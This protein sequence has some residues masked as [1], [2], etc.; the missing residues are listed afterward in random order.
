MIPPPP[1]VDQKLARFVWGLRLPFRLLRTALSETKLRASFT[2]TGTLSSGVTLVTALFLLLYPGTRGFFIKEKD[3][4]VDAAL[5]EA[6]PLPPG[7][8]EA[9]RELELEARQLRSELRQLLKSRDNEEK[10]EAVEA[11]TS[12]SELVRNLRREAVA[13]SKRPRTAP[14]DEDEDPLQPEELAEARKERREELDAALEKLRGALALPPVPPSEVE[15]APPLPLPPVARIGKPVP[16]SEVEGPPAPLPAPVPPG[17]VED[18]GPGLA[19]AVKAIS[20]VAGAM[21][22]ASEEK[23]RAIA[24]ART[25]EEREAARQQKISITLGPTE[26]GKRPLVVVRRGDAVEQVPVGAPVAPSEVEGRTSAPAPPKPAKA[27]VGPAKRAGAQRAPPPPAPPKAPSAP[28][29][30]EPEEPEEA[31]EPPPLTAEQ[32]AAAREEEARAV[33]QEV[34]S[35]RAT[36]A[37]LRQDVGLRRAEEAR[38]EKAHE[39]RGVVQRFLLAPFVHRTVRILLA[40]YAA[41]VAVEWVVLALSRDYQDQ[42][43]R[44][45]SLATGMPPDDE[46]KTPRLRLDLR[47]VARKMKRRFRG[48]YLFMVGMMA[49][50]CLGWLPWKLGDQVVPVLAA[51]WSGYWLAV[52][53]LAKTRQAWDDSETRLPWYVR[54]FDA[55]GG[56]I[57]FLRWYGAML[58]RVSKSVLAPCQAFERG[59]YEA[60][61]LAVARLMLGLPPIYSF[62]RPVFTVAAQHAVLARA[63]HPPALVP[64]PDAV[65]PALH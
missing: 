52:F 1:P 19:E 14:P 41:L 59:S 9:T 64:P 63:E 16:P 15:G 33:E 58:K 39:E 35:V 29:G 10:E 13:A 11:L 42:L 49:I 50:S 45:L 56:R 21:K 28:A 30:E 62:V 6:E 26:K 54:G 60:A 46:E 22:R 43:M 25:D 17:G 55:T 32:L 2:R 38:Q 18:D 37:K 36:L 20:D 31:P 48:W 4:D 61:G 53:T 7:R 65:S 3:L 5:A 8:A 47:W 57:F 23:E 12:V 24:R 34:A 44:R 51:L 40:L 27:P